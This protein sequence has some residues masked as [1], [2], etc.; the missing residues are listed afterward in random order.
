M[1]EKENKTNY[2]SILILFVVACA[3]A[4]IMG[5]AFRPLVSR[6]AE[7][8]DSTLTDAQERLKDIQTFRESVE[9]SSSSD[10]VD[11]SPYLTNDVAPLPLQTN[12]LLLSIRNI[13]VCMWFTIVF[14]WI[15]DR[16]KAIIFRLGGV[17][18]Q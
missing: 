4:L 11:K 2:K 3:L 5:L 7:P 1:N 6:A 18:K 14:V 12:D 8:E 10:A 13:L 9:V 15:Y 16:L 17:K